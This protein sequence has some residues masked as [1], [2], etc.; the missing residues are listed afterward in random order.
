[1]KAE[2]ADKGVLKKEKRVKKGGWEIARWGGV[3]VGWLQ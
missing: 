3:E 2:S 1:M